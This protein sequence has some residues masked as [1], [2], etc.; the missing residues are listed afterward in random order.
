VMKV[1]IRNQWIA[2]VDLV[3]VDVA[4]VI[5]DLVLVVAV[6][7]VDLV[8][9]AQVA[10]I[11]GLI[12]DQD[13]I[14]V[15][16]VGNA[17]NNALKVRVDKVL[18]ALI[19]VKVA[20]VNLANVLKVVK[21]KDKVAMDNVV[22]TTDVRTPATAINSMQKVLVIK[23]EKNQHHKWWR[24]KESVKRFLDSLNVCFLNLI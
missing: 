6:A 16:V 10:V 18:S 13:K 11:V 20:K 23:A 21:N 14:V 5:A 3:K 1:T 19:V 7:I 15:N 9:M 2:H 4:V 8:V 12:V 17:I 24:T 22:T